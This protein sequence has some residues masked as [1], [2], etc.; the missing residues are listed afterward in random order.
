MAERVRN[1]GHGIPE[2]DIDRRYVESL[3]N[4][5]EILPLCDRV[6]LYDN[7]NEFR[8]VAIFRNGSCV[9][10]SDNVPEWAKD[11]IFQK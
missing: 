9:E 6:E 3:K 8:Q 4:L 5:Q 11:V 10:Q 1:G 2:Q 7:T